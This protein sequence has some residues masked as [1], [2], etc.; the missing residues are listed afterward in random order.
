MRTLPQT[1]ELVQIRSINI[2]HNPIVHLPPSIYQRLHNVYGYE[3]DYGRQTIYYDNQ[4]VHDHHIQLSLKLSI[5]RLVETRP[6]DYDESEDEKVFETII[7]YHLLPPTSIEMLFD[8]CQNSR[9]LSI[10]GLNFQ[11]LFVL[12]F[13]H[14]KQYPDPI[15]SQILTIV[16]TALI[17]S[18]CECLGGQMAR[19]VNC[20]S[21][22]NPD[23][24]IYISDNEQISNI[25]CQII[26]K[27]PLGQEDP[28]FAERV[29][30]ELSER[31]Y[32]QN[33][34]NLWLQNS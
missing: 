27:L 29:R 6:Y 5:Q 12:I 19:L 10:Y 2:T 21:G 23:V 8:Y 16:N 20:L 30:Q 17:D 9:N 18:M 1:L 3:Y 15:Q 25:I 34:I 14:I 13:T 31:G 33:I 7:E 22:F 24:T 28:Q 26:I 32:S 4:N 11:Q